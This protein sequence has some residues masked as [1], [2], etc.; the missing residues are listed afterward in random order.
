MQPLQFDNYMLSSCRKLLHGF[1]IYTVARNDPFLNLLQL[2]SFE[3]L[4]A[5]L[6]KSQKQAVLV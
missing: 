3:I 1:Q 6:R 2:S 5:I 4:F